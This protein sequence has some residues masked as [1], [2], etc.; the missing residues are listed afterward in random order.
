MFGIVTFRNL[1]T[2]PPIVG[3]GE[4]LFTFR[5]AIQITKSC[6]VSEVLRAN[7]GPK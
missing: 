1:R 6:E 3:I 7:L 2:R 4:A 5:P